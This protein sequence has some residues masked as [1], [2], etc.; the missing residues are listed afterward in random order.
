MGTKEFTKKYYVD[1]KNTDCIKWDDAKVKGKLPMFIADMDFKTDE[2][3]IEG[4]KKRIEH[5][6][7]GYSVLPKDYYEVLINWNKDHNGV[8]FKKE[9]IRF[10]KGAVDG[11]YQILH[12]LT[13]KNDAVLITEPVYPPFFSSVKTAKRKLVVS[14]L[15]KE[16]DLYTFD[17]KDIENK[18]IKNKVKVMLLCTPHNPLARVWNSKEL[19]KLLAITHKHHVLVVSDEVHADLIMP[20]YKFV[21]TLSFNKYKNDIISITAASKT[22]SLA[23]YSNCHIIIPND[24]LRKIFDT[25]QETNHLQPIN[26]ICAYPTYLGYKYGDS[27]LKGV[28]EVINENYNYMKQRLSKY[29]DFLPLEGTYL[30]FVNFKN[31]TKNAYNFLSE[32]CGII[33]NDGE[34]FAKGYGSWA[35]F[36]LATSLDNIK[37]ACDRIEKQI[38]KV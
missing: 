26:A 23:L 9:W 38:K 34:T 12:A 18:I 13:K 1:R 17:F 24:K 16:N 5:G 20:G 11:I 32:K 15:I 19:S 29:V 33:V 4:L 14:R 30:T 7:Y 28:I 21:Q 36:N 27:W 37:L 10:S 35:R 8:T 2:K 3:I 31:Y 25:Y 22:F 6:S